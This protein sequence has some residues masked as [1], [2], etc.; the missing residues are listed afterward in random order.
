MVTVSCLPVVHGVPELL[1]PLILPGAALVAGV[2]AVRTPVVLTHGRRIWLWLKVV[3]PGL[4]LCCLVIG[5]FAVVGVRSRETWV[6]SDFRATASNSYV[7][8]RLE[9]RPHELWIRVG[10][11][12]PVLIDRQRMIE[13]V[14]WS[15]DSRTLVYIVDEVD[16]TILKAARAADGWRATEICELPPGVSPG[17][18]PS[19]VWSPSAEKLAMDWGHHFRVRVVSLRSRR[20]E[21][22]HEGSIRHFWW[23]D[24][25]RVAVMDDNGKV[26]VADVAD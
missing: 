16:A 7:Q 8:G 1:I 22:V 13:V 24:D 18:A 4:A 6:A 3:G 9:G 17:R 11:G 20:C 25:Q 14:D 19:Y 26:T 21:T 10:E 15:P 2:L 23:V 5:V 12:Q